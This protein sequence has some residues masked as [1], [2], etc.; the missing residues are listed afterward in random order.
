[1]NNRVHFLQKRS[2][3]SFF[4]LKCSAFFVFLVTLANASVIEWFPSDI[5]S[6]LNDPSNICNAYKP[7]STIC[8][9][10]KLM[11]KEDFERSY[12]LIE[13][14][15]AGQGKFKN[16]LAKCKTAEVS[17]KRYQIYV[18]VLKFVSSEDF[19]R[20]HSRS[21]RQHEQDKSKRFARDI[22]YKWHIDHDPCESGILIFLN[23]QRFK[24]LVIASRFT[25]SNSYFASYNLQSLLQPSIDAGNFSDSVKSSIEYFGLELAGQ[26]LPSPPKSNSSG[27]VYLLLILSAVYVFSVL[28]S[29]YFSEQKRGFNTLEIRS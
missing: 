7:N 5:P 6:P 15:H 14:I 13:Q 27:G 3:P 11:T 25:K 20:F 29:Y 28:K 8:D 23:A 26:P 21:M 1:M 9:P 18:L 4:P 17:T 22:Y 10:D 2:L 24:R 16:A 19:I 12:E